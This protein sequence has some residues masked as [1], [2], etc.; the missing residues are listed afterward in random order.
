MEGGRILADGPSGSVVSQYLTA[1]TGIM[2]E[3]RWEADGNAPQGSVARLKRVAIKNSDGAVCE[4]LNIRHPIDL[5]MEFQVL[6][7]DRVLLPHFHV[8][9]EEGIRVFTTL[10]QDPQWH[11]RPREKG[12]F[13][14]TARIPGNL[15]TEGLFYVTPALVTVDPT[16]IQFMEREA[17]AFNVV[18][19]Q[20]GPSARGDW[21]NR[22]LGVV[23]PMLEWRTEFNA[24]A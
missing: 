13:R 14:S 12:T 9:N 3:H 19:N 17:V 6:V 2:A 5:E 21:G 23:R 16:T 8:H 18:D 22:L 24:H 15:L 10:D 4:A 20:D 11:R 1:G 7:G